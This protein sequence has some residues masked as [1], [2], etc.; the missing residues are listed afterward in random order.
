M[1]L[2][3]CEMQDTDLSFEY[4]EVQAVIKGDILSIKNPA[5]GFIKA[6]NIGEII[7]DENKFSGAAC[8]IMCAER[9]V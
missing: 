5:G 1:V 3:N 2:E 6:D 4:S 9:A 7:L 8:K